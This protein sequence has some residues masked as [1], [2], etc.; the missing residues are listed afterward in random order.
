MT[1]I[2]SVERLLFAG[3]HAKIGDHYSIP[4]LASAITA[5]VGTFFF[6]MAT[7]LNLNSPANGIQFVAIG[8]AYTALIAGGLRGASA[9][10]FMKTTSMVNIIA[11]SLL[12]FLVLSTIFNPMEGKFYQRT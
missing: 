8:I 5:S 9:L 2:L 7:G 4:F 11:Y 10:G 6:C 1:S 12:E 3:I